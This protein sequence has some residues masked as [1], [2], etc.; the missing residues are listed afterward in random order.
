MP[1]NNKCVDYI[2]LPEA[3]RSLATN[4]GAGSGYCAIESSQPRAVSRS[5]EAGALTP[6][7]KLTVDTWLEPDAVAILG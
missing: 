6:R 2:P 1:A 3:D 4:N 7:K 5:D